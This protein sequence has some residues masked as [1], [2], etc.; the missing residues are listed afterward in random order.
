MLAWV[1]ILGYRV[2]KR[3]P[4]S[5]DA[6]GLGTAFPQPTMRSGSRSGGWIDVCSLGIENR[7]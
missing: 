7:Y 3:L 2:A 5:P 6:G 1:K 4:A